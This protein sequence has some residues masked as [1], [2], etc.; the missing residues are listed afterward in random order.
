MRSKKGLLMISI[1]LLLMP[2]ILY[3]YSQSGMEV[4]LKVYTV[5]YLG[6]EATHVKTTVKGILINPSTFDTFLSYTRHEA[7]VAWWC[8]TCF[9]SASTYSETISP[10][11]VKEVTRWNQGSWNINFSGKN[12]VKLKTYGNYVVRYV[13]YYEVDNVRYSIIDALEDAYRFLRKFFEGQAG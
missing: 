7:W 5:N 3:V 6:W 1:L 9:A 2:H 13:V 10:H 11:I 12:I 8:I 4:T